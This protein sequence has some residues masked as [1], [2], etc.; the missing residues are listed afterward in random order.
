MVMNSIFVTNFDCFIITCS[1][2]LN[3]QVHLDFQS[4]SWFSLWFVDHFTYSF[5]EC[6]ECLILNFLSNL[7]GSYSHCNWRSHFNILWLPSQLADAKDV[8]A[9]VCNLDGARLPVLTPNLKVG[10]LEKPQ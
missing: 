3:K 1:L 9:A 6:S 2:S 8:M 7:L 4:E 10:N 5:I